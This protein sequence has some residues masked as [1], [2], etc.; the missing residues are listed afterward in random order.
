[1]VLDRASA[2]KAS[3]NGRFAAFSFVDRII[4]IEGIARVSGLYTIPST[5]SLPGQSSG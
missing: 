2:V 1:M 5:I 3:P 4:S